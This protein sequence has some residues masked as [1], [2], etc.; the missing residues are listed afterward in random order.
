MTQEMQGVEADFA[1]ILVATDLSRASERARD[2]ALALGAP[3]GRL[4]LVY[5]HVLPLPDWPDPVYVP[6]W[7][8]AEPSLRGEMLERLRLFAAPARAAGH[9]VDVV[10]EEG[11]P[12]DVILEVADSLRPDLIAMGTHGRRRFERWVMGSTAERVLR[13]APAPVLTV[14]AQGPRRRSAVGHVLCAVGLGPGLAETIGYASALA[15]RH[16][17]ALTVL[18]VVENGL[19]N[20]W[21]ELA[22]QPHSS[23]AWLKGRASHRLQIALT[24]AAPQLAAET[25]VRVG[26]PAEEILRLASERDTDLIVMGVH[27]RP[28]TDAGFFGSTADK[29]VRD[30]SCGVLTV[31][32]ALRGPRPIRAEQGQVSAYEHS[33]S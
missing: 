14:S 7:M 9:Q 15:R 33:V 21:M 16:G 5:A 6:D 12:A 3:G 22:P 13:L 17:S 18:Y 26:H 24:S 28:P 4:T 8:P 31:R 11:N 29:V 23:A 10:L 32:R 27:D 20:M 1:R 30:A 2:Y 25:V 19:A